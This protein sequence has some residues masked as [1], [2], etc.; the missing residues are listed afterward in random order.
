MTEPENQPTKKTIMKL[1]TQ[2]QQDAVI[3]ADMLLTAMVKIDVSCE[4]TRKLI[5]DKLTQYYANLDVGEQTEAIF[6]EAA[7]KY[8]REV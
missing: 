8:A 1:P 3:A 5:V 2:E 4:V 7:L 6:L